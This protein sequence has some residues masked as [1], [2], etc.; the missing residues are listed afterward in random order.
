M[1][2]DH[3]QPSKL[4]FIRYLGELVQLRLAVE[5]N[6]RDF[7]THEQIIYLV[8]SNIVRLFLSP[9]DRWASVSP[10]KEILDLEK[11]ELAVAT[12]IVTAEYIFSRE[13]AQQKGY[14]VFVAAEHVK[15]IVNYLDKTDDRKGRDAAGGIT[16]TGSQSRHDNDSGNRQTL[17]SELESIEQQLSTGNYEPGALR[18]LF[19][20]TIPRT[21][22]QLDR[23]DFF[24]KQQFG[25]LQRGDWIR[26]LRL[27]PH[28][29]RR[30]L[31]DYSKKEFEEWRS[32][33]EA[34]VHHQSSDTEEESG[35]E[36]PRDRILNRDA[37]VLAQ[38]FSL[39]DDLIRRKVPV[40]LVFITDDEKIHYA[41]AYRKKYE[42]YN[43]ESFL[44]RSIQFLPVLNIQEMPNFVHESGSTLEI[45]SVI[46]SV[47]R[48]KR[49]ITKE[50]L[51]ELIHRIALDLRKELQP[52]P[53][54]GLSDW[55][56]ALQEAWHKTLQ[57]YFDLDIDI[58]PAIDAGRAR[59]RTAW[60]NLSNNAVSL[61]VELL[62]RR[63]QQE[64][65]PLAS[66][67]GRLKATGKVADLA[68]AFQAYQDEQLDILERQHI[69]W[70]LEWLIADL[71]RR[72]LGH[73]G[74]GPRLLRQDLLGTSH[75]RRL[76]TAVR[77]VM[78]FASGQ[79]DKLT[80]RLK[81][82][83][84]DY[85]IPD[86]LMVTAVVAYHSG[87]WAQARDFGV[88]AFD[89]L[90]KMHQQDVTNEAVE[91]SLREFEYLVPL[92]TRF[93]LCQ[94]VPQ[95]LQTDRERNALRAKFNS[96]ARSL[97]ASRANASERFD[98]FA[99]ARANA[100]LGTLHLAAVAFHCIHP[101]VKLLRV[102]EPSP[103]ALRA[104]EYLRRA[105]ND[106]DTH[107][108]RSISPDA[109]ED[110]F[111]AR[112]YFL[113]SINLISAFAFFEFEDL[114]STKVPKAW[115]DTS[116]NFA[117]PRLRDVPPHLP[118]AL[119]ICEWRQQEEGGPKQRLA[120]DIIA[121]CQHVLED[122]QSHLTLLDRDMLERYRDR[123]VA[124]QRAALAKDRLHL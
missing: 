40:K 64:L 119:K 16:Q 55:K 106:I 72:R 74:R 58:A 41:V 29:G 33:M 108:T 124:H 75:N 49:E 82:L 77:D 9:Y 37:T 23:R 11:K 3:Q 14:P 93:E 10:F 17:A 7:E 61:N 88:R 15:E 91:R 50:F 110:G 1:T 96:A 65:G 87:A 27:A 84:D 48:S 109:D 101:D 54:A 53:S 5:Q 98:F 67:L 46:D 105:S 42:Q 66:A 80:S 111:P 34:F 12:A 39:N 6:L 117:R 63:L 25:R 118:I 57:A 20:S 120:K 32:T 116:L 24:P 102:D 36:A 112:L 60:D 30:W 28:I 8:D 22:S 35:P 70:S 68:S 62:A 73:I 92:C 113:V 13:L 43:G 38:L 107:F 79:A 90:R 104:T 31:E 69:E 52:Q 115:M 103:F 56:A 123:F 100:E 95:H 18:A 99:V 121:D 122:A 76:E 89:R 85:D 45:R 47:L 71:A 59:V 114:Y 97:R 21:I 78:K 26:P 81:A 94:T 19:G 83:L 86:I 2:Q 44:R 51:Q 4:P